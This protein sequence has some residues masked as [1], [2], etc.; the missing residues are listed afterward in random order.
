M[1]YFKDI[2]DAFSKVEVTDVEAKVISFESAISKA[3]DLILPAVQS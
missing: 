3:V 1:N 2:T